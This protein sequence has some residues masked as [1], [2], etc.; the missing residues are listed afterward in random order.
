M[1]N[2]KIGIVGY[3]N[4]GKGVELVVHGRN[5]MELV[6]VFTRRNPETICPH[7]AETKVFPT[8]GLD[9]PQDIDVLILCGG[10]AVDLPWQT[11]KYAARYNVVDSFDHHEEIPE[12][13]RRVDAAA[14]AGGKLALI[15]CGW[16]PGIFSLMRGLFGEVF[17]K[18]NTYT[19]WGKGISQGHS[20]A[21][22][23]IKGVKD[24][25]QYTIPLTSAMEEVMTN[26]DVALTTKEM[27]RRECFVVAEEGA[28]LQRIEKEIKTIPDYFAGYETTVHFISQEILEKEHGEF[29]HGGTVMRAGEMAKMSYQLELKSNPNFT[30][31]VLVAYARAVYKMACDGDVG[32]RTVLDV[33]MG[34]LGGKKFSYL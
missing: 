26:P 4:L 12:H 13:F 31:G 33:P 5:D 1:E 22:R 21:I 11:P 16:D 25:R 32:C 30:A 17:P 9:E 29:P 8:S 18:G 10:S 14:R 20:D 23:R 24:A 2:I 6:G 7:F 34:E 27:H 3:G 28:D 19:F 15:S